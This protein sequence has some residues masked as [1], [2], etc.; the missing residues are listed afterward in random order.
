MSVAWAAPATSSAATAALQHSNILMARP[1][2]CCGARGIDPICDA[3]ILAPVI[4]APVIV[5]PTSMVHV[6][7]RA[8]LRRNHIEFEL[9][10]RTVAVPPTAAQRQEQRGRVGQAGGLGLNPL[11][12]R[13]L[14]GDLRTEQIEEVGVAALHLLLRQIE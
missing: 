4:V 9:R 10:R 5:A 13:L 8:D 7:I 11:E 12:D 1:R 3:A 6:G 2:S 14:I